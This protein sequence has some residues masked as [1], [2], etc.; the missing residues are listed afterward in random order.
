M[1]VCSS[2]GEAIIHVKSTSSYLICDCGFGCGIWAVKARKG[3]KG[4]AREGVEGRKGE[5]R[6]PYRPGVLR[7]G[8]MS[9]F[10]QP[11]TS[12]V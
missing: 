7:D 11:R 9:I 3:V 2:Y 10:E 6:Y 4:R 8:N 12:D 5:G 1:C